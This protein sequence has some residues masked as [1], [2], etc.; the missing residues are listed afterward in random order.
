MI[1]WGGGRRLKRNGFPGNRLNSAGLPTTA[2]TGQRHIPFS[3][4]ASGQADQAGSSARMIFL[5]I[6]RDVVVISNENYFKCADPCIIAAH[7]L[8]TCT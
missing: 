8:F 5:A 2:I 1:P 3:E 4:T 7:R 6:N